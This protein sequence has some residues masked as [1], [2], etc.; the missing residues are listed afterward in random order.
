MQI[1]HEKTILLEALWERTED[2]GKTSFELLKFKALDKTTEVASTLLVRLA[3]FFIG[4]IFLLMVN[5][6]VSIWLGNI[7][8][9]VY[10]GFFAV[11][12]FYGIAGVV[13]YF[14]LNKWLKRLVGNFMVKQ[15]LN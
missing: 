7:L 12:A 10:L 9:D 11:A 6:G 15:I 13:L 14:L 3:V 4:N 8:G 1:M 2:Y 5:I